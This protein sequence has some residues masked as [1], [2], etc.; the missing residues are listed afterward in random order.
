MSY[1]PGLRAIWRG[2]LAARLA[3]WLPVA[4]VSSYVGCAKVLGHS[5]AVILTW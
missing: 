4:T 5:P 2:M 3:A 1:L